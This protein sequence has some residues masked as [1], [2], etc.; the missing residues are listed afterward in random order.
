[1]KISTNEDAKNWIQSFDLPTK[2]L[3]LRIH[4]KN[5]VVYEYEQSSGGIICLA[6]FVSQLFEEKEEQAAFWITDWD[7]SYENMN[8]FNI[9]RKGLNEERSLPE[10]SFHLFE[11]GEKD[12]LECFLDLAML[13]TWDAYLIFPKSGIVFSPNDEFLHVSC[14]EN[15]DIKKFEEYFKHMDF[16]DITDQWNKRMARVSKG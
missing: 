9:F 7:I 10:A 6:Q 8:L 11:V 3:E 13:F 4:F 5:S 15:S 14:K 16:K 2:G 1:M 12:K